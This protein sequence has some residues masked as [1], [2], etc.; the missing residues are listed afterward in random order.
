MLRDADARVLVVVVNLRSP[1]RSVLGSGSA[2]EGTDHWWAQRVTAVALIILGAWFL[3]ALSHSTALDYDTVNE[4]IGRPWNSVM[5]LLLGLTLAY[6][7]SLGLQVVIE[8]YV[9]GSFLKVVSLILNKFF[10]AAIAMAAV[11]AVL[12]IAFGVA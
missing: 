8:D 2:K 9:H 3:L 6:H 7:S 10:H 12:K 11:F 5:L 1:L 4:W